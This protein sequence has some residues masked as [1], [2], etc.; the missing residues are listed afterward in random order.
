MRASPDVVAR[1]LDDEVV[2]VHLGT[3]RIYSLNVT[4]ARYW[5]LLEQGL[6][7]TVIVQRMLD[8]FVVDE[9]RLEQEIAE[10]TA[11]LVREGLVT[12]E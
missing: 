6:D 4:G 3:N 8:E 5:E 10:I 11:H 2:L 9:T 7:H 1:R 12:V